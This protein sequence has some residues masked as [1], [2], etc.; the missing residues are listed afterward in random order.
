MARYEIPQFI[1]VE[2]RI[3]GPITFKQL[4]YFFAILGV[5][6]IFWFVL[7]ISYFLFLAV[8]II[9]ITL[10]FAFAKVGGRSFFAYFSALIQ[11]MVQPQ[12]FVWKRQALEIE[13]KSAESL[14]YGLNLSQTEAEPAKSQPKA[15][16]NQELLKEKRIKQ[17]AQIL[18]N[19]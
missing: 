18:D 2:S 11:Y 15:Q 8:P 6:A 16:Q 13:K 14:S 19:F 9:I 17:I 4:I 3:L 7:K 10:I 12:T 1:D 5:L